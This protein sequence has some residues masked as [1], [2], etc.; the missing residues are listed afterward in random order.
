MSCHARPKLRPRL[1]YRGTFSFAGK[2]VSNVA[3]NSAFSTSRP[4]FA[5]VKS[6]SAAFAVKHDR[7]LG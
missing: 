7:V 1:K 3:E 6:I 5:P 2:S 4:N